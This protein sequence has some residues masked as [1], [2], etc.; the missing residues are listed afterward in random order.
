LICLFFLFFWCTPNGVTLEMCSWCAV[1][2]A[3]MA[4]LLCVPVL[5][6]LSGELLSEELRSLQALRRSSSERTR[7]I[8][9]HH[10]GSQASIT[11]VKPGRGA[12]SL[13]ELPPFGG[14]F[15]S[16][17]PAFQRAT[18]RRSLR[19]KSWSSMKPARA[20]ARHSLAERGLGHPGPRRY[21]AEAGG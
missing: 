16:D 21:G 3:C 11:S 18:E 19:K 6:E 5:Q 8:Y 7:C 10:C 9:E 17:F 4:S 12:P 2:H 20:E 1:S 13:L 14:V 15:Q